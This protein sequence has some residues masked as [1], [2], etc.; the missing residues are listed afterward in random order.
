MRLAILTLTIASALQSG[1][2]TTGKYETVLQS[3]VGNDVNHLI[4][5]WGPPTSEYRMPNGNVMYTYRRDAGAVAV[6]VGNMVYAGRR[7][8]E[9]TFQ[10]DALG[11]IRSWRWEG[12]NCA[13]R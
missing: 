2:A 13:V 11:V 1:C 9:T 10:V 4:A 3:W 6:P 8:C 5:S 7:W 12:N